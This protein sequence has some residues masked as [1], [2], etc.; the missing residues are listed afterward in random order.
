M[1]YLLEWTWDL[2]E[3]GRTLELIDPDI[4]STCS[5]EEVLRVIEVSLLCTQVVPTMRPSMSRVVAL[6][7]GDVQVIPSASR[8]RY[9]KDWQYNIAIAGATGTGS[10]PII[11]TTPNASARHKCA[12]NNQSTIQYT[13]NKPTAVEAKHLHQCM[14]QRPTTNAKP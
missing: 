3:E 12:A 6:L 8:P 14:T 10:A 7:T 13:N 5:K 11:A 4:E 9:I 2:Y 1:V